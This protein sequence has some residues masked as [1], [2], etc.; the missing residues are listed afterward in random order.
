M[1]TT[2]LASCA[3]FDRDSGY[4]FLFLPLTCRGRATLECR[5]DKHLT[6]SP[7]P[8][9]APVWRSIGLG[10]SCTG[11]LVGNLLLH[12][13]GHGRD[14]T[15][16]LLALWSRGSRSTLNRDSGGCRSWNIQSF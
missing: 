14:I 15:P 7:A 9:Y 1:Q 3:A 10:V 5:L 2:V 4:C 8:V 13:A 11:Q 6:R 12:D 16:L